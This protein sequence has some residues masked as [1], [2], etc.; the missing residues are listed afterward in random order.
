[1]RPCVSHCFRSFWIGS[2]H[3]DLPFEWCGC[4]GW[5]IFHPARAAHT[6]YR[7]HLCT[8]SLSN[9]QSGFALRIK[10]F[11]N[12]LLKDAAIADWAVGV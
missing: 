4:G 8:L 3:G 1:M 12:V 11:I 5:E 10:V 2:F 9:N 6:E 7:S